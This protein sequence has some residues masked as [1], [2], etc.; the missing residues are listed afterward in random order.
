ML[1]RK[2]WVFMIFRYELFCN[3]LL[4]RCWF[5]FVTVL[6]SDFICFGSRFVDVY[7]YLYIQSIIDQNGSQIV[8]GDAPFFILFSQG[9]CL[10]ILAPFWYQCWYPCVDLGVRFC[11]H[12]IVLIPFGTPLSHLSADGGPNPQITHR[13]NAD[14]SDE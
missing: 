7:V 11:T 6:G 14:T 1:F 12:R 9:F 5:H 13:K 4:H 2:A 3:D 8:P 10:P